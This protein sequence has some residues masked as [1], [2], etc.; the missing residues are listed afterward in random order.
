MGTGA[1]PDVPNNPAN[2]CRAP[3]MHLS[4]LKRKWLVVSRSVNDAAATIRDTH[5]QQ[6]EHSVCAT[7]EMSR[8]PCL[9]QTLTAT[10]TPPQMAQC[11]RRRQSRRAAAASDHG[12]RKQ[13]FYQGGRVSRWKCT[14]DFAARWH[15]TKEVGKISHRGANDMFHTPEGNE[16]L[17]YD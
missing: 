2:I 5:A 14:I 12:G 13:K 3:I 1:A 8:T 4:L 15:T 10:R 17:G 7:A 16:C 9:L 6:H 11:A